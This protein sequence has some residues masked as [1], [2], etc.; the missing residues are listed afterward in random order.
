MQTLD[1]LALDCLIRLSAAAAASASATFPW[2]PLLM[3]MNRLN[4][5]IVSCVRNSTAFFADKHTQTL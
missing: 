3:T 1:P 2:I 4:E 5:I